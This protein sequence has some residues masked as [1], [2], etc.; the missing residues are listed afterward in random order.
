[1]AQLVKN[2]PAMRETW[3]GLPHCRIPGLFD[4]WVG[5]IPWR[6]ERLPTPVFW[7]G[8]LPCIYTVHGVV[9]SQTQLSDSLS[10]LTL[11]TVASFLH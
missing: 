7:P 8:E 6:R 4:P 11:V 2:L 5:K 9:K 3:V 10:T 1:M